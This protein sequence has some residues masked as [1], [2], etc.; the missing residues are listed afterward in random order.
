MT[1]KTPRADTGLALI[2]SVLLA[3]ALDDL[4]RAERSKRYTVHMGFWHDPDLYDKTCAVCMA[5]ATMAGKLK[6]DPLRE[7]EPRCYDD[8]TKELL[9]ALDWV[10]M[11]A[12]D[13]F[14][15]NVN[16]ARMQ[17]GLEPLAHTMPLADELADEVG[18]VSY[19]EDNKTIFKLALRKAVRIMRKAD[20]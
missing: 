17:H 15:D 1:D 13:G 11:F 14:F 20:L 10:R 12:W 19:N 8:V 16:E 3:E 18:M 9:L 4:I 7:C 6:A 2:P 5:G